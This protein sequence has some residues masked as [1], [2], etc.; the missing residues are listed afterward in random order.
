[1]DGP[2]TPAE[3]RCIALKAIDI[4]KCPDPVTVLAALNETVNL[5]EDVACGLAMPTACQR[6]VGQVFCNAIQEYL[7]AERTRAFVDAL[8]P[9]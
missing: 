8:P 3:F 9:I 4:D 2:R 7:D 5:I 1:M 6:F